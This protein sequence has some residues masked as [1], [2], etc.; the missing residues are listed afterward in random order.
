MKL[1]KLIIPV[2]IFL[3]ISAVIILM[4]VF[5]S[6]YHIAY[7]G[8]IILNVEQKVS[9]IR[10][11]AGVPQ[12]TAA[13]EKDFYFTLGFLHAQERLPS[14]LYYKN[15]CDLQLTGIIQDEE[16]KK[17]FSDLMKL[18]KISEKSSEIFSSL[19][20]EDQVRLKRYSDGV[21]SL[22][23]EITGPDGRKY[24]WSIDDSLIILIL[25]EF[26]SAYLKN[27][28]FVFPYSRT[29][30][31]KALRLI[32]SQYM[33][34]YADDESESLKL[35]LKYKSIFE[36]YV[37]RYN[38]GYSYYSLNLKNGSVTEG[39]SLENY[40]NVPPLW[41]PFSAEVNGKKLTGTTLC[42]MPFI[43][44]GMNETYSF[45][46][47]DA[48]AD[49]FSAV[50]Y[51]IRKISNS[52][53]YFSRGKWSDFTEINENGRVYRYADSGVIVSN[54]NE[55]IDDSF[56]IC[57]NDSVFSGKFVTA[58]LLL[59]FDYSPEMFKDMNLD[60]DCKKII[61]RNDNML[62][63]YYTGV[64][65]TSLRNEKVFLQNF[66]R[67]ETVF[68]SIPFRIDEK[69]TNYISGTDGSSDNI[70]KNSMSFVN[71]ERFS[72]I[73]GM[74]SENTSPDITLI[75]ENTDSS[76]FYNFYKAIEQKIDKIPVTSAKLSMLYLSGWNGSN[77]FDDISPS[78]IQYLYFSLLFQTIKDDFEESEYKSLL[79]NYYLY[80]NQFL[81]IVESGLSD[82]FDDKL[83]TDKYEDID[84]MLDR[85]FLVAMR[86][87]HRNYGPYTEKWHYKEITKTEY[88]YPDVLDRI[89]S[90]A[91]VSSEG[92]G[93]SPNQTFLEF[94][95]NNEKVITSKL[96]SMVFYSDDGNNF[97][98]FNFPMSSDILS[99]YRNPGSYDFIP[100][101]KFDVSAKQLQFIPNK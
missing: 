20:E 80:G 86:M 84:A 26:S 44:H 101:D 6:K 40:A 88:M 9:V 29:N 76:F 56:V 89:H 77:K 95:Y 78:I 23:T 81:K 3:I 22:L 66:P 31:I 55:V 19:P 48:A 74:F 5:Y 15:L 51:N 30:Y 62:N 37:G 65:D 1:K 59:P 16:D 28:E 97:I 24:I 70:F 12:I 8:E 67:T 92:D 13:S 71:T 98:K 49:S 54:F 83:T 25:L 43:L 34:A 79:S 14:M 82:L 46:V 64:V 91:F 41:F 94:D 90:N 32:P 27:R 100:M 69:N 96:T 93:Y 35:L 4:V 17:I 39:Y 38:L 42:V 21:N 85:S 36:K 47:F 52:Y 7:D 53:Q 50:K 61:V 33:S 87:M 99:K 57:I 68:R 58:L 72:R 10:N 60:V 73:A 63:I 18:L 45:S 75:I 2:I 11:S